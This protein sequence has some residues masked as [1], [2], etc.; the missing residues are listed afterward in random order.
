MANKGESKSLKISKVGFVHKFDKNKNFVIKPKTGKH[1]IKTSVPIAYV[2][3]ELLALA[4]N[5][6]EVT[7][8]IN[9]REIYVDKRIV[10]SKNLSVGFYDI[11][12]IP[13]LKK[14]Y[15]TIF[16]KNGLISLVEIDKEEAKC[17][18]CKIVKKQTFKGNKI[19]LTTNDGRS[20]VTD[21][22]AYKTKASI[23]LDLEE[24]TIKEYFPLE[25]G[26]KAFIIGGKH[27]GVIA[28][29]KNITPSTMNKE[30][31]IKLKNEDF[32]FE[33]TQKNVFVIE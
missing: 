9:N 14:Y 23:K 7:Y 8:I 13:K 33:T 6:K 3:K 28:T 26:R 21:N 19:Q 32:E 15:R 12:E 29:I 18:I 2:L 22:K 27:V 16:L 31:L 5:N 1:N 10:K 11:I 25:K 24:N 4:D 30:A 17:K 20:I